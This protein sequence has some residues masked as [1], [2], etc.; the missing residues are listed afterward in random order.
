MLLVGVASLGVMLWIWLGDRLAWWWAG[1][2]ASQRARLPLIEA[3]EESLDDLHHEPDARRAIILCY[4]HFERWLSGSGSPRAPWETPTEFMRRV[5][6]RLPIPR[7]ATSTLTRL[8]ERSRFSHHELGAV[9]RESA[10]RSLLE[11]RAALE[12]ARSDAPAA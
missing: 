10:V 9:E 2:V 3:I 8:F 11:I 4:R 12:E 6:A 1:S 7:A 5:L